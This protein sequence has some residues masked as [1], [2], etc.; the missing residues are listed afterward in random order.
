MERLRLKPLPHIAVIF[1]TIAGGAS[2]DQ[3]RSLCCAAFYLRN[4]MIKGD[5]LRLAAAIGATTIPRLNNSPPKSMLGDSLGEK[6]G[7]FNLV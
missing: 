1:G 6:L 5:L 7:P 4:N 3:I 2:G